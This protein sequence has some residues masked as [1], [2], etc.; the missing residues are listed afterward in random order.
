M[1]ILWIGGWA[2]NTS[3]MDTLVACAFPKL[4]HLCIH[5]HEGFLES[6]QSYNPDAVVGYSLG[7]TLLINNP[8]SY[9]SL[10]SYLIAP[11]L[12]IQDATYV[13]STQLKYLLRWLNKDPLSAI[14]DFYKRSQLS[15]PELTELPYSIADLIWGLEVLIKTQ[16]S[17][18]YL[19]KRIF[20]GDQDPLINPSFFLNNTVNS[21][22]CANANHKLE[23]Y[24]SYLPF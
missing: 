22:I 9:S 10:K 23:G 11:F 3:T 1:K 4:D 16:E 6:I 20:L 8:S 12:S 18:P 15:F 7:A 13:N 14:N 17:T 5:P 19:N 21:T 2:I 24:L